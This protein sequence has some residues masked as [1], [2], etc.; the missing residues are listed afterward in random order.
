MRYIHILS[1]LLNAPD[2][3]MPVFDWVVV[4]RVLSGTPVRITDVD[5][6]RQVVRVAQLE[7]WTA[8]QLRDAIHCSYETA[9]RYL[10]DDP[11]DISRLPIDRRTLETRVRHQNADAART[12]RDR[13]AVNADVEVRAEEAGTE[14]SADRAS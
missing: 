1:A 9:L 6:L 14:Q 3:D 5:D 12:A 2:A 13:L 8:C 4:A 10:E 7:R 11:A